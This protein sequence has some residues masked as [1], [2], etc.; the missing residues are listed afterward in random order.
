MDGFNEC[1]NDVFNSMV[2]RAWAASLSTS[3]GVWGRFCPTT[4]PGTAWALGTWHHGRAPC[5][6]PK[7]GSN[8]KGLWL[9]EIM[10]ESLRGFL[11]FLRG[12]ESSSVSAHSPV[13]ALCSKAVND[14]V[15]QFPPCAGD[16]GALVP[17][18]PEK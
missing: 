18:Y 1:F 16:S 15:P 7:G 12:L 14:A 13:L 6:L 9:R 3:P 17:R 4:A 2:Q 11:W 5:E 8:R 10:G